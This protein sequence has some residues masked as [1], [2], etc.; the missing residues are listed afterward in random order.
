MSKI[1]ICGLRR[2]KDIEAVNCALP[3]FIGFVFANSHRQIDNKTAAMLKTKLDR[4]IKAV[5]VF[6][7]H[8]I[9]SIARLFKEG[10]IDLIQLHGDEDTEYIKQLRQSCGSKIVKAV[11]AGVN[12]PELPQGADYLLFDTASAKRGGSGKTFDWRLLKEYSGTP[13]F[14]AG[15]LDAGNIEEAISM[16]HPYCV[17]V[18]SG[19]ETHGAKDREKISM[20]VQTVRGHAI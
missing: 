19:A 2:M 17:D 11:S 9:S 20:L 3:D 6:V 7:N 15:G 14:L 10:T 13:Y 8:D 18:S 5:G 12:L 16:L 1:K 4:R